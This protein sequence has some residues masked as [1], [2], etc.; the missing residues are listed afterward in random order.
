MNSLRGRWRALAL[1][2]CAGFAACAGNGEGLDV[3][4]R[5]IDESPAPADDRFAEIQNTIFTPIC[6]GCHAGANAPAGLRLESGASYAL[7][8]GVA[9]TEV[10]AVM[11]V[12]PGNP[13]A[14]YLVQKIEG[15]AAV[16]GRMPLGGPPLSAAN[17]ALVREWIADGA[18]APASVSS[19]LRILSSLPSPSDPPGET[20]GEIVLAFDGPL[21]VALI[22]STVRLLGS[23]GDGTFDDGNEETVRIGSYRVSASSP[24][25]LRLIPAQPLMDDS[26][27]LVINGS[28]PTQLADVHG[29]T[30]SGDFVLHLETARGRAQ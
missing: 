2:A 4:G 17:I 28:A 29:R 16:G 1:C 5:P 21:D 19:D 11:R 12:S 10:P 22:E 7:L 3:G 15:T 18:P 20:I 6:T 13:D 9:S 26:Y 30:L 27:R 24:S 23:G 8:V 14:S 25:V